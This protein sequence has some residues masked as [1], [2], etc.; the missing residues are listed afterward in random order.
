MLSLVGRDL[1]RLRVALGSGVERVTN[2]EGEPFGKVVCCFAE[3]SRGSAA[4]ADEKPAEACCEEGPGI[5][6][7]AGA[8]AM[9]NSATIFRVDGI[10]SPGASSPARIRV[11]RTST[12]RVYGGAGTVAPSLRRTVLVRHP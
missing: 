12:T 10:R 9:P 7:V 1:A 3:A 2:R 6:S 4:R 11:R 8:M 5:S